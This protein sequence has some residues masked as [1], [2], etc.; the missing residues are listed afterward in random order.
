M[1]TPMMPC[2]VRTSLQPLERRWLPAVVETHAVDDRPVLHQP[3]QPRLR[4]ARLRPR[5]DRPDLDEAEAETEHLFRYFGILVEARGEPDGRGELETG[6]C[7]PQRR[8]KSVA[9][10]RRASA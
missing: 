4:I 1:L 8:G 9:A 2:D 7:R 5:R 3:E 6:D 10:W